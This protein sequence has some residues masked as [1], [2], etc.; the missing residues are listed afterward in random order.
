MIFIPRSKGADDGS[1]RAE[2]N[3][4]EGFLKGKKQVWQLTHQDTHVQNKQNKYRQG[5]G[6]ATPI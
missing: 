5:T 1:I 6:T 3:G 4:L 2:R